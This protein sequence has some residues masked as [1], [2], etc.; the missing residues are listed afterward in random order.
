MGDGRGHASK[1]KASSSWF[2]LSASALGKQ[3]VEGRDGFTIAAAPNML[4][5][6]TGAK[7]DE[8]P[9]SR[10]LHAICWEYIGATAT[11]K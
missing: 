6:P 10:D 8:A 3:A 7:K 5:R 2:V 1:S 4:V 11:D 9:E